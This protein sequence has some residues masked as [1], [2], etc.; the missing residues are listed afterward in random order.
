MT[1]AANTKPYRKVGKEIGRKRE[2]REVGWVTVEEN[3]NKSYVLVHVLCAHVQPA[4]CSRR[5]QTKKTKQKKTDTTKLVLK[6]LRELRFEFC[7][8]KTRIKIRREFPM[9]GV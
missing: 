7:G 4:G 8:T 9:S 1:T 5:S 6:N 3:K 2:N